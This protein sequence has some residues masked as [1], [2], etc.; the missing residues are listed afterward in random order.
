MDRQDTE[1]DPTA[2][3]LDRQKGQQGK[4]PAGDWADEAAQARTADDPR[5]V[6]PHDPDG[7]PSTGDQR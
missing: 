1:P 3:E 7:V 5:R 6:T 4:Q 2:A